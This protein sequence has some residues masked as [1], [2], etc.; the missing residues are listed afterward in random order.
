MKDMKT[1]PARRNIQH[2]LAK[3]RSGAGGHGDKRPEPG[4]SA[5][6]W[7]LE[8]SPDENLEKSP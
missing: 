3:V 1:K 6:E 4:P 2:L 7:D 5:D 8:E